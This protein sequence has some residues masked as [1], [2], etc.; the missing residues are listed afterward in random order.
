[1][2]EDTGSNW[3]KT[4]ACDTED[5]YLS[6]DFQRAVELVMPADARLADAKPQSSFDAI[7]LSRRYLMNAH[8]NDVLLGY[9]SQ[10]RHGF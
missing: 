2:P 4:R 7:K 10:A 5:D 1:M 8:D 3:C 9:S 6:N